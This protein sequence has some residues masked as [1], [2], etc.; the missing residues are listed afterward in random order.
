LTVIALQI[1]F[2]LGGAVVTESVFARQGLGKLAIEAIEWRDLPVVQGVVVFGA[3]AYT[4]VNL[5]ADLVQAWLNP[6]LREELA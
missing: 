4:L 3:L 5:V 2:L 6:R 1:G